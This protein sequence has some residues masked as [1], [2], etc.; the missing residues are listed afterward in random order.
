MLEEL[1]IRILPKANASKPC[2]VHQKIENPKMLGMKFWMSEF[3]VAKCSK[4][5]WDCHNRIRLENNAQKWSQIVKTLD[6]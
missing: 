1:R 5:P 2:S 4:R 6:G 3:E